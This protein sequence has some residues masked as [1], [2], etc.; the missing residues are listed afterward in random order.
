MNIDRH[1]STPNLISK[2]ELYQRL[3][4]FGLGRARLLRAV[5]MRRTVRMTARGLAFLLR[6]AGD[7][8]WTWQNRYNAR[9]H[10]AQLDSRLLDDVGLTR[11]DIMQASARPFWKP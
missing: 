2:D 4:A 8:L 1:Q 3:Y 6:Q 10:M 7:T 11:A 5:A 9:R